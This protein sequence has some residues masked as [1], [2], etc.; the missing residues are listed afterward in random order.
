MLARFI[1]SSRASLR[2]NHFWLQFLH[3]PVQGATMKQQ[4]LAAAME[5]TTQAGNDQIDQLEVRLQGQLSGRV[6]NLQLCIGQYG[7]T[8]RGIA[9]TYYAKQLAQHAVMRETQLP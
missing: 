2:G 4:H 8:L 1:F 5:P 7:V 6:R 3:R 9:R